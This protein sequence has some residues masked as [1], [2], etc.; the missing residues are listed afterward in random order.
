MTKN[1]K[2]LQLILERTEQGELLWEETEREGVFQAVSTSYSMRVKR[3][4]LSGLPTIVHRI[5]TDAIEMLGEY[6]LEVYNSEG[7][8]TNEIKSGNRPGTIDAEIIT[9]NSE[10]ALQNFNE[11]DLIRYHLIS[12]YNL[13]KKQQ[14]E[15]ETDIDILISEL[16]RN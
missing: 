12:I 8:M 14:D 5:M 9:G 10:S 2:L 11:V 3:N 15:R 6:V 4:S 13:A 1:L 16:E 7:I